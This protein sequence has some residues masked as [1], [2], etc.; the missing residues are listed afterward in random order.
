MFTALT[1]LQLKT[2]CI[3]EDSRLIVVLYS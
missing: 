2:C 1:G 3:K